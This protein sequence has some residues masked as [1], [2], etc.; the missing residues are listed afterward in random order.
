MGKPKITS[1]FLAIINESTVPHLL[2]G[3]AWRKETTSQ[4]GTLRILF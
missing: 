1:K 4:G 2:D 3:V